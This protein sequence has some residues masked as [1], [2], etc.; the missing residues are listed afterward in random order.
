MALQ[1]EPKIK[2]LDYLK[3]FLTCFKHPK[4]SRH[5]SEI[6]Q[7]DFHKPKIELESNNFE[8]TSLLIVHFLQVVKAI[9]KK[10][11][12]KG[13][14]PVEDNLNARIKGKVNISNTLKRNILQGQNHKTVCNYQA[15]GID[16][17][18]NRLLKKAL[19]FVQFYLSKN[20]IESQD[21]RQTLAY[22]LAPF[23]LV[24]DEIDIR[25]IKN[26]KNNAFFKEYSE[27]LK[28]AKMILRRFAYN[29]KNTQNS[30]QTPPFYIDMSLLFEQYVYALLLEKNEV[31]YQVKASHK[32]VVDFLVSDM[33]VDTKYKP[34][35]YKNSVEIED[36]R[37]LS[38]YARDKKIR[39]ELGLDEMDN[40]IIKCLI[41]Y[42]DEDSNNDFSNLWNDSKEINNF[43]DFKKIGIKLPIY[44]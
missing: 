25:T 5:L 15:F 26:F 40:A 38:G 1:V 23:E 29:F 6:Y 14:Y 30:K 17:A 13:Y 28:L 2:N 21:V 3:M 11:L 16:C 32:T 42:P 10:G 4:V 33:V 44:A 24:S 8:I 19:K 36:I 37:Q 31:E 41:I 39:Q 7:I 34:K 35:K 20:T 12:K 27:G 9:S 22:C 43:V 18:E